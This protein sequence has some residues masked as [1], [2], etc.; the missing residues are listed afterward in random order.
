MADTR[1]D[2]GAT[3]ARTLL[4]ACL[5]TWLPGTAWSADVPIPEYKPANECVVLLHGLSRTDFSMGKMANVLSERGYA[6]S[7]VHYNS[8]EHNIEELAALAINQGLQ[9]CR[10]LDAHR[11][12]F[13]THSLG[14]ILVRYYLQHN[15]IAELG[16]VVMLAPPNHGSQIIDIFGDIP[17]FDLFSGEPASQLGTRGPESVPAKLPPVDFELGVIAGTR[18]ISPIFSFALPDRDDGKVTVESTKVDGMR[19]FIEMPFN[20]TFIMRSN[21]VIEQVIHFLQNGSFDHS[22]TNQEM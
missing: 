7:N 13:V 9:H 22:A 20:H 14:G 10:A 16:R 2:S 15:E 1:T 12:H 5:M 6:N 3:L 19:D 21:A 11:I 17:G 8:R 4:M 18:S